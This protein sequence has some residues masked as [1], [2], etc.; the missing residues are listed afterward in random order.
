M[1]PPLIARNAARSGD[2]KITR[3]LALAAALDIVDRDAA[4][5]RLNVGGRQ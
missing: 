2:G 1:T 3:G 5:D 4:D